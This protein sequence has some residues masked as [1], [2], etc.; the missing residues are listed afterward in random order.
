MPSLKEHLMILQPTQSQLQALV[1]PYLANLWGYYPLGFVIG[2]ASPDFPGFGKIFYAGR[3]VNQY[4]QPLPLN[5]STSIPI[6][7]STKTFTASLYADC[8]GRGSIPATATLGNYYGNG[9]TPIKPQLT[10]IPLLSLGNYTSG[11]PADDIPPIEDQPVP[12][13]IPYSALDMFEFLYDL[14]RLPVGTPAQTY[15]YSNLGFSLLA[16][17][18]SVALGG[19]TSFA[20]LL[21][22]D[23]LQPLQMTNTQMFFDTPGYLLPL[24]FSSQTGA[25][26]T[27]P[28]T[29]PQYPAYNGA[30]GLVSTPNDMMKWLQFNMNLLKT[31]L[32][33]ILP[34][35][36][37]PT[38]KVM[39]P[40]V[41]NSKLGLGWF[42]SDVGDGL[43]TLWKDGMVMGFNTY[44]SFL[45]SPRPGTIPSKAGV[46]VLTNS[47]GPA[48]Y[49]IANDLLRLMVGQRPLLNKKAYP[50]RVKRGLAAVPPGHLG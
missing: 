19:T 38:T 25:A 17:T 50:K 20:Q 34:A 43:T 37:N 12:L 29:G 3:L 18:I 35:T 14:S 2:Y 11:L 6:A 42:V 15:A 45:Q 24:G 10:D 30:G 31:P 8:V 46:F 39:A 32:T 27:I 1:Y 47:D 26:Y 7:S 28:A 9:H 44:V 5:G 40:Q 13:P 48:V 41:Y 23:I 33:R 4:E 36:Q 49:E 21:Q 16:E 22:T